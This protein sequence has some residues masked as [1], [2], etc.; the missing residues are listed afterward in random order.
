MI[1]II[2]GSDSPI[3]A[4][5][6]CIINIRTIS[7]TANHFDHDTE[8]SVCDTGSI[9]PNL[10]LYGDGRGRYWVCHQAFRVSSTGLTSNMHARARWSQVSQ[11]LLPL[12]SAQQYVACAAGNG[13]FPASLVVHN[14]PPPCQPVRCMQASELR[15]LAY[16]RDR[17]VFV[18]LESREQSHSMLGTTVLSPY[19]SQV[20]NRILRACSLLWRVAT[21]HQLVQQCF[22]SMEARRTSFG[23]SHVRNDDYCYTTGSVQWWW[24]RQHSKTLQHHS[25]VFYAY[26]VVTE[27][28]I[29]IWIMWVSSPMI[30]RMAWSERWYASSCTA[31][32]ALQ[33]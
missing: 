2:K 24:S 9:H 27:I 26:V 20:T 3:H 28:Q 31:D 10:W 22:G 30:N 16:G 19:A 13:P 7:F 23:L 32:Q 15:D 6:R 4:S 11:D 18:R 12:Q 17:C 21:I 1:S 14:Q 25:F 5:S 8:K 29:R 33:W